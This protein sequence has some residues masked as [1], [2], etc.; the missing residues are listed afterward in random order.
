MRL[1]DLRPAWLVAADTTFRH[2]FARQRPAQVIGL[3]HLCPKC[4][5]TNGGETGTHGIHFLTPDAPATMRPLPGRW[6]LEG[7]DFGELTAIG[8]T[9]DSILVEGG[10]EAHYFLKDGE[11]TLA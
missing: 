11:V 4:W 9:S 6:V 10:C 5:M 1:A 2:D 7:D 8:A 3:H